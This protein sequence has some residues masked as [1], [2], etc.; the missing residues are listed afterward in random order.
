MVSFLA[1]VSALFFT[2]LVLISPVTNAAEPVK[3][4]LKLEAIEKL[5]AQED[6]GDELYFNITEYS[7]VDRASHY[8]VPDF[9]THWLSAYL[10]NVK[11]VAIW[12]KEV[13]DGE[14]VELIISLVER[15]VPPWNVDDLLGS[16]KLKLK[17][18]NNQLEKEWSIPNKTNTRKIDEEVNAFS[19]T[20]DES[21][22]HM[23]LKVK[24]AD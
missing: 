10:E 8:Q 16:V 20:G 21:E 13:K 1:K 6:Q 18:N 2:L 11:D 17:W 23:V 14:S 7:S 3:L 9:P 4:V 15:D 24:K 19:L 12:E 22:Y 5:Q